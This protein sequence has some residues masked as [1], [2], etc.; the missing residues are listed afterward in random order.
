ME[1]FPAANVCGRL[2]KRDD[3]HGPVLSTAHLTNPGCAAN[4]ALRKK[5][6]NKH[7]FADTST[8]VLFTGFQG[9]PG[10]LKSLFSVLLNEQLRVQ[11]MA[12]ISHTQKKILTK[13]GVSVK[14]LHK[15]KLNREAKH[16]EHELTKQCTRQN[17]R[18]VVST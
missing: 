15:R 8:E 4:K 1:I 3:G 6:R 9:Y 16:R 13:S 17:Q 18:A 7:D 11:N 10:L 12:R 2:G 5:S 14:R